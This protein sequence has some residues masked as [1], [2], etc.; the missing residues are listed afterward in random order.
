MHLSLEFRC[1]RNSCMVPYLL[2]IGRNTIQIVLPQ[3]YGLKVIT[4]IM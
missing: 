2:Q 1:G 3:A 4:V